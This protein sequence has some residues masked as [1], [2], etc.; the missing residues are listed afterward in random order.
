MH[1]REKKWINILVGNP[2]GKDHTKQLV[3]GKI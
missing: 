3:Y 1:G 2:E